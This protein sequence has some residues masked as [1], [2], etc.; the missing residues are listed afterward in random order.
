MIDVIIMS[1]I[2]R[3]TTVIAKLADP[4][5][6]YDHEAAW[7][8]EKDASDLITVVEYEAIGL[9]IKEDMGEDIEG[10]LFRR[11]CMCSED[12]PM[13]YSGCI[14]IQCIRERNTRVR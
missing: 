8:A 7:R 12:I 3:T 13:G 4:N 11:C 6:K 2:D 10:H 14:I 1:N 9:T 5:E